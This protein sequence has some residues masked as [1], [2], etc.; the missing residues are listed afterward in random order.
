MGG[1]W[2][3]G[4]PVPIHAM[5][6]GVVAVSMACATGNGSVSVGVAPVVI[7]LVVPIS[8]FISVT[9]IAWVSIVMASIGTHIGVAAV[10]DVS[11]AVWIIR[12][13]LVAVI[14]GGDLVPAVNKVG[15]I[16]HR[17]WEGRCRI[18]DMSR[19]LAGALAFRQL[20][21]AVEAGDGI[22]VFHGNR[23]CQV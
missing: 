16:G 1:K 15:G 3:I 13:G 20:R 10:H 19:I 11:A 2:G 7:S 5:P 22:D 23:G 12:Q 18:R 17:R 8:V 21:R 9:A 6:V 4:F 14:V